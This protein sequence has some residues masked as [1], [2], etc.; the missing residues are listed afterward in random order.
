MTAG[1]TDT[2]MVTGVTDDADNEI[3]SSAA[4]YT[5][6]TKYKIL[7]V[8]NDSGPLTFPGDLAVLSLLQSR[9]FEVTLIT[10]TAVPDAGSTAK[11]KDLVIVSSSLASSSVIA[12][13]GGAKFLNSAVPIID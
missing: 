7:F 5:F 8:T 2:L 1:T 9:G 3:G 6:T 13:A 11:G 10:G 4:P 12:A